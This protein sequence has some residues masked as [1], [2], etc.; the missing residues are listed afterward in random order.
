MCSCLGREYLTL[1][2]WTGSH[3]ARQEI[4]KVEDQKALWSL[5]MPWELGSS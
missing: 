3:A 5:L 4:E 2:G 1:M